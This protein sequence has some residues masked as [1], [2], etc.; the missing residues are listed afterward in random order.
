MKS[1]SYSCRILM[2]IEFLLQTFEKYSNINFNQ[3]PSSRSG[4]FPCGQPDEQAGKEA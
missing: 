4:V 3:S 1:N 2:K